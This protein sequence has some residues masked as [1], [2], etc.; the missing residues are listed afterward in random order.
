MRYRHK[1]TI[2]AYAKSGMRCTAAARELEICRSALYYRL[3]RIRDYYGLNPLLPDDLDVLFRIAAGEE[4]DK[5]EEFWKEY[6][7]KQNKAYT[8]TIW[9]R[10]NVS[11]E[12]F[13]T[14]F[15][16]VLWQKRSRL[17]KEDGGKNVP[18][19]STWLNRKWWERDP[20]AED[21]PH[22]PG[23]VRESKRGKKPICVNKPRSLCWRCRNAVD[24]K[25]CSWARDF[26]PIPGW[27]AIPHQYSSCSGGYRSYHVKQCPLFAA[28]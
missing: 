14:I 27:D 15:D 23:E 26:T 4:P 24:F 28:D 17:W 8:R 1:E 2:I 21:A 19:A 13:N 10:M 9:N 16:A 20:D 7:R 25:V 18:L 3:K 5:F 12:L 22:E 6:P 11:R